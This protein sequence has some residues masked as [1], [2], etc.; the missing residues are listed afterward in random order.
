[1]KTCIFLLLALTL[2]LTETKAQDSIQSTQDWPA[3]SS[4]ISAYIGT[5][6]IATPATLC[7]EHMWHRKAVHL[8]FSTGVMHSFYDGLENRVLGFYGAFIIMTGM[9]KNHFE[10]RAGLGYNPIYLHPNRG[11]KF[12]DLPYMPVIAVSY[13]IQQPGE[14]HY[15]RFSVGTGGFGISMGIIIGQKNKSH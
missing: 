2:A 11:E 14:N 15:V 9:N 5:L 8:G 10:G 6:F 13:R 3:Q 7:Y 12:K 1:M 4:L